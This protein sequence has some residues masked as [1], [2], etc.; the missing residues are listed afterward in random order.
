[1][2]LPCVTGATEDFRGCMLGG[3]ERGKEVDMDMDGGEHMVWVG[4]GVEYVLT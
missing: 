2:T 1:M 4:N 3:W